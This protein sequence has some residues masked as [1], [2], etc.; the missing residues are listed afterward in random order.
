MS[1][2]CSKTAQRGFSLLTASVMVLQPQLLVAGDS[3]TQRDVRMS[4]TIA[5][6]APTDVALGEGGVLTGKVVDTSGK[7]VAIT[8]VALKT[9][10]REIALATTDQEGNF[11]V[12]SLQGGVYE[13]ATSGSEGVY[14]F[15][16]PQ[17]APP[18]SLNGLNLVSGNEVFR[19]QMGGGPFT[20]MGQ[21]IAEHPIITAGAIAGAIAIPIAVSND[22]S[23]PSTP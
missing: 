1:S 12:A 18:S 7:P 10:G 22:D 17:T 5:I 3:I 15:W 9:Q 20:S 23:S 16:A 6:E 14:R 11:R 21:W 4:R 13:V 8:Q 19:G 2:F